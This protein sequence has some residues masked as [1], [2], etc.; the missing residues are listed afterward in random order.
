M[1]PRN[2]S[3]AEKRAAGL[4]ADLRA[5]QLELARRGAFIESAQV[6]E[7]VRKIREAVAAGLQ[8]EIPLAADPP[9]TAESTS[10]G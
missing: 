1:K 2:L 7:Q 4:L 10:G 8:I 6:A 3:D 9:P 5:R